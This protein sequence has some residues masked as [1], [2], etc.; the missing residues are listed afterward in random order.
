MIDSKTSMKGWTRKYWW[1]V[2]FMG[3]SA[4]V[5]A[6]GFH[7][8]QSVII[9]LDQQVSILERKKLCELDIQAELRAQIDSQNDPAWVEMTLMRVLG[10]VP[11]G[12]SK[13]YFYSEPHTP[14]ND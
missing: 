1:V 6:G 13:V 7:R 3:F 5:C 4:A 12:Q 8:K 10:L 9:A 11:E 14:Q 2:L